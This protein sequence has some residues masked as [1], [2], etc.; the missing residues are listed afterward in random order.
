[1]NK[2]KTVQ[3]S[4]YADLSGADL[5]GA[6]LRMADLS[7]ADLLESKINNCIG[8]GKEIISAHLNKYN[9]AICDDLICIGCESHR[10]HEWE[11]FDDKR[12]IEMDGKDA[13]KLWRKNKSVVFAIYNSIE[14]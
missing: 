6:G 14:V 10:S 3:V 9:L 5:S 11:D 2:P 7:G 1:M 8:N 4:F 12:I 13:L